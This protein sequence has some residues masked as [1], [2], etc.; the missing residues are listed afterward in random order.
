MI[1]SSIVLLY[2][3]QRRHNSGPLR[4]QGGTAGEWGEKQLWL[5]VHQHHIAQMEKE[6]KTHTSQHQKVKHE[7]MLLNVTSSL[8]V[9]QTVV[10]YGCNYKGLCVRA[11]FT[12]KK[13][14][15]QRYRQISDFHFH[16]RLHT[17][18][19]RIIKHTVL[20]EKWIPEVLTMS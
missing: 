17:S 1:H 16:K 12:A 20:N 19:D 7:E 11:T 13:T 10:S 8:R 5:A 4:F 15:R 14:L 2:A 9:V 6:E 18:F 3:E